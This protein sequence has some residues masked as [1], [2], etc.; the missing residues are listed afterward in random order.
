MS[1]ILSQL[2]GNTQKNIII[3]RFTLYSH[4]QNERWPSIIF[5]GMPN[6]LS[7]REACSQYAQVGFLMEFEDFICWQVVHC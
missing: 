5:P 7:T 6:I 4:S 3:S 1:F 2:Y